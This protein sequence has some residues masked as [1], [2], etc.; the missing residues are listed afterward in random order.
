LV[1]LAFLVVFVSIPTQASK[2]LAAGRVSA[3]G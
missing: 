3:I 2:K 1:V